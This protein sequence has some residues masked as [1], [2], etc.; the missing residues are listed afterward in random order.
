MNPKQ[1]IADINTEIEIIKNHDA[2]PTGYK[3][4]MIEMLEKRK[5]DFAMIEQGEI[6]SGES[7]DV[8]EPSD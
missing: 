7:T 5:R 1:Q 3:K 2:L 4:Q 6:N 8:W